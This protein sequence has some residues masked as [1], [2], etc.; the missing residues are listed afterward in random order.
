MQ[1]QFICSSIIPAPLEKVWALYAEVNTIDQISPRFTRVKF[2][3]VDL[4][5]RAGSEIV[6]VG[7]YSPRLCWHARIDVFVFNSHFVD[8]QISDRLTF[9]GKEVRL[10]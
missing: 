1:S 8:M 9:G 7:K 4:P 6:F 10:Q 2:E 5:R 3:R